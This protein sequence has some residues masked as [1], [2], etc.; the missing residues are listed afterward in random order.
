MST[1][2]TRS[3]SWLRSLEPDQRRNDQQILVRTLASR[4]PGHLPGGVLPR[5]VGFL[6]SRRFRGLGGCIGRVLDAAAAVPCAPP[7]RGVRGRAGG[8]PTGLAYF[9]PDERR[10]LPDTPQH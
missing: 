7:G 10:R 9:S 2:Q 4:E 1:R 6:P 8:A 5:P 3:F